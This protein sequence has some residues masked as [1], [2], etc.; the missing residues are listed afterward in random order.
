[1]NKNIIRTGY[2]LACLVLI[3]FFSS[4]GSSKMSTCQTKQYHKTY[5]TKKNRNNYGQRYS[6]KT[7]S[8]RKEYVI[9]NGIAH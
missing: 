8:V 5:N 1:M 3:A 2:I 7:R 4:C 6:Q 9:K